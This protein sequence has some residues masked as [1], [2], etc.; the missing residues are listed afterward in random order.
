MSRLARAAAAVCLA[1]GTV[2]CGLLAP[3]P[4]WERPP[5]EPVER[6]LVREDALV[7][8]DFV[9]G[10]SALVHEDR[11]LP[12]VSISLTLRRGAASEGPDEVG[13]AAFVAK[14]LERG[15]GSRDAVSFAEAVDSLG[16]GFGA[17]AGWDSL[18]VSVSGLSRDFDVL[19]GLLA[20]AVLRPLFDPAEAERVRAENLAVLE[21]ARENPGT[22]A[23]WQLASAIYGS[24]RYG[25]PVGGDAEAVARLD[26]ASA[27]D[28]HARFFVPGAAL[29]AITG[30]V[31]PERALDALA[32]AFGDWRPGPIPGPGEPPPARAPETRQL[33]IVNRPDQTQAH[34]A[35]GHEGIARTDDTRIA[36]ALLNSVVGGSGF[37]SRLMASLRSDEGLTYGVGSGF[38][39]RRAPG[40]FR[41]STSTKVETARRALD[42]LLAELERARSEPP[43]GEELGW[44]RTLAIGRFSLGLETA[45]DVTASLVDL[46]VYGLPEDSL[47]T[48]RGR[49]REV[50]EA[51]VAEA[52]RIRL[53]PERAA[54]VLVG[55][56]EALAEQLEGLGP[57]EIVEP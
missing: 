51:D 13:Q 42:L 35:V 40:P 10:F 25:L 22:L 1:L 28:F 55:P 46:D 54:I 27:R 24:H 16:A 32:R 11:G 52:A 4:A 44:A 15:A 2:G 45:R 57:L 14:L 30:D 26:A 8:R 34:I 43:A 19:L 41:V 17:S 53:H 50:S 37:S 31:E 3:A 38:A 47:D 7:R 23:Q 20:D 56:A 5:P 36:A 21:R 18:T 49:V 33:R 9:S 29:V 48:Y 12:L 39:L 6:T